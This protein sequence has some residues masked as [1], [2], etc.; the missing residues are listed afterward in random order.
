MQ[1]KQDQQLAVLAHYS[2]G[3]IRD[4]TRQAQFQSN[5]IA[6]AA[7]DADGLVR[8]FELSGDATIMARYMGQVTVFRALVP[9]GKAIAKYPDFP[10]NNFIDTLALKRWKKLGIVPSEL[11]SDSEFIRRVTVDLC[12]RLP[13]SEEVKAFLAEPDSSPRPAGEQGWQ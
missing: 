13:T 1:R 2:D 12:G 11:C 9:L 3:T 4:V 8:T 5:E 6:V 7:V 10:A